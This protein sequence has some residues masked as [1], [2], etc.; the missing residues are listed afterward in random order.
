MWWILFLLV[1]AIAVTFQKSL[2]E[3]MGE[4]GTG[5]TLSTEMPGDVDILPG[6]PAYEVTGLISSDQNQPDRILPSVTKDQD[7]LGSQLVNLPK[8][9]LS[10]L[11][12]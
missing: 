9:L 4:Y 2:Y 8:S 1:I 7:Q 12:N 5:R 10:F 6:V 11:P 3:K